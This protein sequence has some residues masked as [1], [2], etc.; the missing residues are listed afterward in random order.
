M[1]QFLVLNIGN[2]NKHT[3]PQIFL[4]YA[5]VKYS[6]T[7]QDSKMIWQNCVLLYKYKQCSFKVYH[8]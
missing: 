2:N 7:D 1:K 5:R 8:S 4:Y 6:N 3:V